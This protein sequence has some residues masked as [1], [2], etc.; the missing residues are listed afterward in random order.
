[1]NRILPPSRLWPLH[2]V[3]TTRGIEADAALT[4]PP[5]TLMH[6]AGD[7]VARLALA[8][9]PHSRR[10]WV[11]AGPGNNGGDGLEAAAQL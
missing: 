6:R 7:A 3:T 10:V 9:A 2:G 1:M 5:H 4:L 8:V 11:A